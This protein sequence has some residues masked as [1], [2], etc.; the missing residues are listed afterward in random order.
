MRVFEISHFPVKSWSF[1]FTVHFGFFRSFSGFPLLLSAVFQT[2][3]SFPPLRKHLTAS[4]AKSSRSSGSGFC[5]LQ[6]FIVI[7]VYFVASFY[8]QLCNLMPFLH[9][10]CF[11]P[12]K[13]M[14]WHYHNSSVIVVNN[15]RCS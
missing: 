15:H 14:K 12:L 2:S 3:I 1:R 4:T 10:I 6:V 9:F 13:V 7:P 8:Q 11:V 5:F